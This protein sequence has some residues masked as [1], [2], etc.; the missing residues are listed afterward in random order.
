MNSVL[1][2]YLSLLG[3]G[4]YI[5]VIVSM[6][7]AGD[8]MLFAF[9]FLTRHG[10]FSLGWVALFAFIGTIAGDASWYYL[11]KIFRHSTFFFVRWYHAIGSTLDAHLLKRR[12]RLIILSK[13]VYGMHHTTMF[14]AG[15]MDI[16][17]RDL[18]RIDVPATMGWLTVIGGLGYFS[19]AYLDIV[20]KYVHWIEV[21]LLL[22]LIGYSLLSYGVS[23]AIKK[24]L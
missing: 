2:K 5:I 21:T 16:P 4:K 24:A 1:L 12:Q 23:R 13:F 11:G 19:G 9:A 18:M 7:I 8:E 22:V 3:F 20:T 15:V 10:F 6:M 17:L 14:R